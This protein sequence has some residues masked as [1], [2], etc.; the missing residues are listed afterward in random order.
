MQI[1]DIVLI[2]IAGI[3]ALLVALF[4]YIYKSGKKTP[5]TIFFT[6]LRFLSVFALLLLLINPTF[7]NKTFFVEKPTL[8]VA[9]DNSSSIQ[10]LEKKEAVT[11]WVTKLQE[12]KKIAERFD[13]QYYGFSDFLQDSLSLTFDD[14]Q[15]NISKALEDLDQIYKNTNAPTLLITDGNQTYGRDYQFISK[16]LKQ[17]LFPVIVGDTT[18]VTDT[19]IEQLNVNRYA[20]LKN[21][22]PV[23]AILAYSGKEEIKS[24]FEVRLGNQVVY[25]TPVSF[26][27]S[28]TSQV[29]NFTLPAA[30]VGIVHYK[31]VLSPLKL[32]KNTANNTK[33][34]A[35]EVIDQKTK[36]LVVSNKVHPDVGLIKKSIESNERSKVVIAKPN[37]IKDLDDYQL[38]VVYQPD[39]SF[40]NVFKTL[41]EKK[42]NYFTITGKHTNWSFLNGIQ[43]KYRQELTRQ[44]ENYL[45]NFNP[46][47]NT[48]LA[49]DIG[50]AD[51]PP[52]VG[53]FGTVTMKVPNDVLLYRKIG[54]ITTDEPL[55]VTTEEN[56]VRE[57]VLFGEGLWR[58]RA[59]SYLDNQNFQQFD[60][61]F[62]KLIQY[63]A[64]SKRKSRLN[65]FSESFYYGNANIKIKAEYFT[66]NYEFDRRGSLQ[67][68]VKNT[69]TDKLHTVP[70]LLKNNAY[71]ADLTNLGSGTYQ[72]TVSVANDNISRSGNFTILEYDVEQQLPNADVT[73]LT[74]LATNTKGQ[75]YFI[76][77]QQKM[78]Q[79]ILQ[80][81][82]YQPIQKSKEKTMSLIDWKYILAFLILVLA[83][84]WFAR[85]YNG[86]I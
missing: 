53:T 78:I 47:Y 19:R 74:T 82:R 55:L 16:N 14:K 85:K 30:S 37:E 72:Y 66:K 73:K 75:I 79:D 51:F 36:V 20:F 3:V 17:Q 4:Q 13:I 18:K 76:D 54:N 44:T 52:L 42:K 26:S 58:W 5:K 45:P 84:E 70:M 57:A 23:E 12:N 68:Q 86:L 38:V 43:K 34:F 2:V 1:Q 59:K 46:N 24:T 6:F 62:S 7:K 81:Q 69:D 60:D 83:I 29:I 63:L 33:T 80:D 40:S 10:Y 31:A 48:F 15:T 8:V 61:F 67:I 21:K 71:E 41:A 49:D 56:G 77:Q 9:I 35:V 65:V 11:A 64:S 50:F 22:F 27:V 28:K 39:N 32:E 25:Q